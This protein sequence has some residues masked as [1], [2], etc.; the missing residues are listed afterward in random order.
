MEIHGFFED[1]MPYI[2]I[3][4]AAELF[5]ALLD[6]GY[7]GFVM[8]SGEAI[9]RLGLKELGKTLYQT[10]DGQIHEGRVYL[11]KTAWLGASRDVALD[12][13]DGDFSL[14][15][16]KLLRSSLLVMD[17]SRELLTVSSVSAGP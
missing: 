12:S 16:M 11:G 17:P 6:T 2:P 10:A 15:G 7:E 1:G 5:H 3:N 13:T 14:V 4:V 9:A 8:L